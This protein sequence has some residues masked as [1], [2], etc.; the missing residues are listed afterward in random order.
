MKKTVLTSIL[1]IL[2]VMITVGAF[3]G[4]AVAASGL[5]NSCPRGETD[6]TYPGKCRLY[7]DTN[8]DSICDRSQPDPAQISA[9]NSAVKD[10]T[11]IVNNNGTPIGDISITAVSDIQSINNA[12][13]I[14]NSFPDNLPVND[15]NSYY[16]LPF[17]LIL[18]MSYTF[19][20]TLSAKKVIKNMLHRKIWNVILLISTVVS[21]LLGL[22]L[23]L[24]TDFNINVT[25]PFDMLFWH[26]ETGIA[27]GIIAVFHIVWHWRYFAKMVKVTD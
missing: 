20:W 24:R 21:A 13:S 2:F 1:A 6:C 19:T 9:L 26:V 4:E 3:Y 15:N 23:I 12:V 7:I 5:W 22:L 10:Q 14:N 18:G 27:L 8:K 11:I 16:F 25:L 17:F